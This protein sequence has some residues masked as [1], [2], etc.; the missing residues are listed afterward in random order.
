MKIFRVFLLEIYELLMKIMNS[1]HIYMLRMSK[2]HMLATKCKLDCTL[3][4]S[5]PTKKWKINNN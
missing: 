2:T 1:V 4:L 3:R 5:Y